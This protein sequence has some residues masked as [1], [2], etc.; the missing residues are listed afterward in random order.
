MHLHGGLGYEITAIE[1]KEY[2][3][4]CRFPCLRN[5]S[6]AYHSPHELGDVSADGGPDDH[7]EAVGEAEAG[8]RRGAV[9][10][11]REVRDDHLAP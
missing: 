8:Q 3:V 2:R 10:L 7:P 1:E 11:G 6:R 5:V 4:Q 9:R